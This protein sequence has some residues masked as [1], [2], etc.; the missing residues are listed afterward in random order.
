MPLCTLDALLMHFCAAAQRHRVVQAGHGLHVVLRRVFRTNSQPQV[1]F[2]LCCLKNH[3]S[4]DQE[5][6][7]RPRAGVRRP[8]APVAYGP[9]RPTPSRLGVMPAR[10]RAHRRG[11]VRAATSRTGCRRR[12]AKREGTTPRA[13]IARGRAG[14]RLEGA[15]RG[16]SAVTRGLTRPASARDGPSHSCTRSYVS[17]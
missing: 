17:V 12:T 16:T 10:A 5:R 9:Q 6:R 4:T 8:L 14:T 2:T 1:S 7:T 15:G 11:N 13:E 3:A